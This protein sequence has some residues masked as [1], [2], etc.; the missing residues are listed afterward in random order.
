MSISATVRNMAMHAEQKGLEL[1]CRM[2]PDIPPVLLGDAGRLRQI[3]LNLLSNGVKYNRPSGS[4]QVRLTDMGEHLQIVVTDTGPGLKPEQI[5]Q[6]EHWVNQAIWQ[7]AAVSITERPYAEAVA[8][9]AMALFG[10]KY[11]DVVRVVEIEGFS[12]ELCGGTH[13]QSSGQV[14]VV[15]FLSEGSIGAGVRRVE[16]LVG[17]DAYRFFAAIANGTQPD[18]KAGAVI[19]P[20]YFENREESGLEPYVGEVMQPAKD[21]ILDFGN[22]TQR[23]M[24]AYDDGIFMDT[25]V[26]MHALHDYLADKVTFE[27][28]KVG[29]FADLPSGLVFDC[30]GLGAQRLDDDPD[31]VPVQGHLILLRDQVP[32]DLQSMILVYFDKGKT[33]SGQ[34]VKRSFYIFPKHL[35]F[36]P[37]SFPVSPTKPA[38]VLR[39]RNTSQPVLFIRAV[40]ASSSGIPA[41]PDFLPTTA[42]LVC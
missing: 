25:A 26:M 37:A 40:Q 3:L 30:T 8:A 15:K 12:R 2:A 31:V 11:G 22:G 24:V 1:A 5:A 21:V 41:S 23:P 28:R 33:T 27:Q 7:N 32:A 29:N 36:S 14:G 39:N 6:V 34:L 20:A 35:L 18:F 42:E 17:V 13:A 38:F 10:E 4:L 19:V 16:A 9:G